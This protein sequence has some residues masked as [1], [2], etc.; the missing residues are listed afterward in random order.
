MQASGG[1]ALFRNIQCNDGVDP[2]PQAEDAQDRRVKPPRVVENKNRSAVRPADVLRAL[3]VVDLRQPEKLRDRAAQ[4]IGKVGGKIL[5]CRF[6]LFHA[7]SSAMAR[8]SMILSRRSFVRRLS[9]SGE[10][11]CVGHSAARSMGLPITTGVR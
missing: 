4:H 9:S 11:F 2:P 8:S 10:G 5:P 3:L 1:V 6:Q 7:V